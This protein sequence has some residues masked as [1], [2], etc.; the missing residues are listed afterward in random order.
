M[1]INNPDSGSPSQSGCPTIPSPCQSLPDF[2][3]GQKVAFCSI[4]QTNVH[5]FSA[6]AESERRSLLRS[7]KALC[8]RYA[9]IIPALL[10]GTATPII[11]QDSAE[12][13]REMDTITITG[14]R[15]APLELAFQESELEESFDE[16]GVAPDQPQR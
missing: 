14:G 7:S 12:E 11:A 13:D 5:N 2:E 16:Q 6:L 8:A 3:R 10:L 15:V 4:C 9:L 1:P